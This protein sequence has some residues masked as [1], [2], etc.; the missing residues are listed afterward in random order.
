MTIRLRTTRGF[1]FIAGIIVLPL[2]IL[3]IVAATDDGENIV[4]TR[5]EVIESPSGALR[6]H[7]TMTNRTDS[8]YRD[9]DV[10]FH[11][12]DRDERPLGQASGSAARLE[13][14]EQFAINAPLPDGAERIQVY[15]LEWK[16][17]DVA[18]RLGPY[19]P[20]PLGYIQYEAGKK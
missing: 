10:R 4:L 1:T 15:S 3:F 12:L 9:I 17:A 5:N 16:T 14:G 19:A 8:V 2:L 11:F 7:A 13:P 18:R 20:W 6:W